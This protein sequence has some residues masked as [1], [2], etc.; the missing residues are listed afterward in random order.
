MN[1]TLIF[2]NVFLVITL[3]I[4]FNHLNSI[5]NNFKLGDSN[6]S[7]IANQITDDEYL[8]SNSI[9]KY[10]DDHYLLNEITTIE[11][12]DN[13]NRYYKIMKSK[14][15]C[16]NNPNIYISN[17]DEYNYLIEFISNENNQKLGEYVIS[18]NDYENLNKTCDSY[19]ILKRGL[20]QKVIGFSLYGKKRLYYDKLSSI[21]SQVK[22]FY[23]GWLIRIYYDESI[24]KSIIC[25]IECNENNNADFCFVENVKMKLNDERLSFNFSYIHAAIV[26]IL[27]IISKYS[28]FLI[29]LILY[30]L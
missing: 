15:K 4:Y 23:P 1:K 2:L 10:K 20:S 19:S 16:K 24:D 8:L 17:K 27:S 28:Y 5:G 25:E 12:N 30:N 21:T 14:C 13:K 22:N 29:N 11:I 3:F 18:K 6:P 7:K 9:S 26:T